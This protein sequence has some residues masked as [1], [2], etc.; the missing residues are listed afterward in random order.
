[1]ENYFFSKKLLII[2]FSFLF[3]IYFTTILDNWILCEHIF[4]VRFWVY[5][6][7]FDTVHG[8][9]LHWSI[10]YIYGRIEH[11]FAVKQFV[12]IFYLWNFYHD[13][14][15]L[16]CASLF[17]S[18]GIKWLQDMWHDWTSTAYIW[19]SCFMINELTLQ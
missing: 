14:F 4:N 11:C 7:S 12:F 1:M 2:D 3:T 15:K 13:N 8:I 18:M 16:A 19:F 9:A 10:V 17:D 6:F 5:S